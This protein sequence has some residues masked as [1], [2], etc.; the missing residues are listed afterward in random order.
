MSLLPAGHYKPW[1]PALT[2]GGG[3]FTSLALYFPIGQIQGPFRIYS[4]TS[5][6]TGPHFHGRG[7]CTGK[8]CGDTTSPLSLAA[9]RNHVEE[10][11]TC[12]DSGPSPGP[13]KLKSPG[14]DQKPVF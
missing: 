10:F 9:L 6:Q 11:V 7:W 3:V 12:T 13:T 4:A 2:P 8:G 1:P 14:E 5:L